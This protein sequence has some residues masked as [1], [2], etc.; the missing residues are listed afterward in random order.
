M[1]RAG[2]LSFDSHGWELSSLPVLNSSNCKDASFPRVPSWEQSFAL[3]EQW[4]LQIHSFWAYTLFPIC[5]FIVE[6][7]QFKD[8]WF[9]C[10][11]LVRRGYFHTDHWTIFSVVC[12]C[13]FKCG[14]NW[15]L[16]WEEGA[17]LLFWGAL[18]RGFCFILQVRWLF[19]RVP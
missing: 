12:S 18:T 9:F 1:I 15:C 6:A 13:Q 8:F 4:F 11:P 5:L 10:T 16:R 3:Q 17:V 14:D 7:F 2:L 19:S